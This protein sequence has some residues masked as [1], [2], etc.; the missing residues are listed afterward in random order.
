MQRVE[1]IN[2]IDTN[3]E[4]RAMILGWRNDGRVTKFMRNKFI[5]QNEHYEFIN[6]LKYADDKRYFLLKDTKGYIGV[7]DFV[8]IRASSC[9]FGLYA[10]PNLKG[11][12]RILMHTILAYSFK[13]LKIDILSAFTYAANLKAVLLYEKFGFKALK[14]DD[15]LKFEIRR[16][17]VEILMKNYKFLSDDEHRQILSIRNLKHIRDMSLNGDIISFD[18]HI[19]WVKMGGG[20][21]PI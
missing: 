15:M 14:N 3:D 17:A 18:K 2:F 16:E 1:L 9:E 10:N 8:D 13:I 21:Q 6:S 7:V 12:G 5:K 20:E 11:I 19:E 4:Q